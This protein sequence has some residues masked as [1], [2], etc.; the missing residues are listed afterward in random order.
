[1]AQRIAALSS[2]PNRAPDTV[3]GANTFRGNGTTRLER[4]N[5][6]GRTESL[7]MTLTRRGFI[8]AALVVATR[9]SRPLIAAVRRTQV[10]TIAG[11]GKPGYEPW[12][13]GALLTPVTNPYGIVPG[14]DGALYFCEVDTGLIRRLHLGAGTMTTFAGTGVNRY[15][16]DG[17]PRGQATFLTPHEIRFDKSGNLYVVER[18]SHVVRRVDARTDVVTTV[19][20][21][22]APGFAGDGGPATKAQL[23]RPHSIAFNADADLLVCDIANHRIRLIDWKTGLIR[24]LAGTGGKERTPDQAPI[25]GTPLNG[26]RSM[27]ADPAGNIYLVLREGNAVFALNARANRLTRVAGTGEKGF[28]GDGGP[29][30]QAMF[31]G[32]KGIACAD[33]HSLYIAD[34]ENHAVRRVDLQTGR[35]ETVLGTGTKGNGPDGDPLQCGLNRPHGLCVHRGVLYVSDSENHRIRA[36]S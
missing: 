21:T 10:R 18:D 29:A 20:G 8:C 31:N 16:G 34:T 2:L 35:I 5:Y 28:S 15:S 14:P 27:D 23:H 12:I 17:G 19:A 11:T 9:R 3:S 26:P 4:D 22:G 6:L 24:T 36:V 1:M 30:L 25:V 13:A 7:M 32:P 33:D